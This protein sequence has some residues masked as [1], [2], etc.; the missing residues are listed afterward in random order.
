MSGIASGLQS[1]GTTQATVGL[2]LSPIVAIIF[3][4]LGVWVLKLSKGDGIHTVKTTGAV[5][6]IQS[7]FPGSS[8]SETITWQVN[9]SKYTVQDTQM[10]DKKGTVPAT[11]VVMYNPSNP[12]DGTVNAPP[13]AWFAYL[14]IA[15]G[16]LYPLVA[17]GNY[18]LVQKS[19]TFAT[20][21][22]ANT[23]SKFI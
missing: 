23:V 22:G 1:I 18:Y 10:I 7:C 11:R 8:C 17:Y 20:L 21:S 13:P 19:P 9:G 5:S 2:W 16:I 12:A 3:V 15:L 6:T 14:F 4:L